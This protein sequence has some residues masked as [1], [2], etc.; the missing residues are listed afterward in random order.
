M[1]LAFAE[2][3]LDALHKEPHHGIKDDTVSEAKGLDWIRIDFR[4]PSLGAEGML[5]IPEEATDEGQQEHGCEIDT[6]R[7]AEEDERE[8]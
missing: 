2:Q 4:I 8:D 6:H 3:R 5:G 1:P 7:T